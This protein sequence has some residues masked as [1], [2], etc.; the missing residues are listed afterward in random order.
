DVPNPFKVSDFYRPL[1]Q[2]SRQLAKQFLSKYD[3]AYEW[4]SPTKEELKKHLKQ[5]PLQIVVSTCSDWN[6]ETVGA[7]NTSTFNH[8]VLLVAF[9]GDRP[10]IFDSY[11]PFLKTLSEKE[12]IAVAL[13]P[14]VSLK[15]EAEIWNY[16]GTLGVAAST[17]AIFIK[18]LNS[19]N[20]PYQ[21]NPD[22]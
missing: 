8:A 11:S 19:V 3:F 15:A 13:K 10:V 4:I 21:L 6:N 18:L 7:C 22:G 16:R 9:D 12:R 2:Q 14:L 5:S 20:I 1:T 17:P